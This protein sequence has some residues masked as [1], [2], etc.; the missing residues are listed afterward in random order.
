ML[1]SWI[2]IFGRTV[3]EVFQLTNIAQQ[4]MEVLDGLDETV[5]ISVLRFAQFLAAEHD[6]DVALFD[7]A[8]AADNGYRISSGDLR[9]KYGL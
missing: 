6:D 9:A 5:Q 1:S 8:K 3:T 4:T 7:E 2:V